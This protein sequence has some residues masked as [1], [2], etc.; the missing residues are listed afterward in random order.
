MF[1]TTPGGKKLK[2]MAIPMLS[3]CGMLKHTKMVPFLDNVLNKLTQS[4]SRPL[5]CPMEP[6][7]IFLKDL[8][9]DFPLPLARNVTH[10]E[11]IVGY[12]GEK[13]PPKKIFNLEL[14]FVNL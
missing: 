10:I 2:V 4:L 3:F 12:D 13:A 6:Q 11:Q 14:Y 5:S 7:R 9:W 8:Q 1:S